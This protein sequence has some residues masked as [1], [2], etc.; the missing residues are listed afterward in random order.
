M[1]EG[2]SVSF[3]HS[4]SLHVVSFTHSLTTKNSKMSS[5]ST[6][7]RPE[8]DDKEKKK[9]EQFT[10]WVKEKSKELKVSEEY[11]LLEFFRD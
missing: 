11:Y 6:L 4:F 3:T 5:T 10:L 1:C 2:G 7:E 8:D 9:A